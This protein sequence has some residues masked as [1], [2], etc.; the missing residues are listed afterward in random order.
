LLRLPPEKPRFDEALEGYVGIRA[1]EREPQAASMICRKT[2]KKVV[3]QL[4]R[5]NRGSRRTTQR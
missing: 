4:R 2:V 1:A 5:G 3:A